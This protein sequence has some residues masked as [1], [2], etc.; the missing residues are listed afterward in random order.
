MVGAWH[1]S[2]IVVAKCAD[3][4]YQEYRALRDSILKSTSPV[5]MDCM[6]PA[7]ALNKLCRRHPPIR[8][9]WMSVWL[10]GGR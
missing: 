3:M 4:Q 2:K 10:P 6:N 5:R 1:R 9:A 7:K 8:P